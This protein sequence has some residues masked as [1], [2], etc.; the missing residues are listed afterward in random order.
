MIHVF[1]VI[2]MCPH[3]FFTLKSPQDLNLIPP[4]CIN[5]KYQNKNLFLKV[6]QVSTKTL[7]KVFAFGCKRFFI[8]EFVLLNKQTC[9]NVNM[10]WLLGTSR[11]HF[12]VDRT[13][14][15]S[16][17]CV[18]HPPYFFQAS[19]SLPCSL[20]LGFN[21]SLR[22]LMILC[23]CHLIQ[24]GFSVI[25]SARASNLPP[26]TRHATLSFFSPS[27]AIGSLISS[28]LQI[29]TLFPGV[30]SDTMWS[31]G[32]KASESGFSRC[33]VLSSLTANRDIALFNDS[34]PLIRNLRETLSGRV[35]GI[36]PTGRFCIQ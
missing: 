30:I 25:T 22:G 7:G 11:K 8:C 15:W 13:R 5:T 36:D 26:A 35:V 4:S 16:C 29:L 12:L 34:I 20:A 23:S 18:P 6:F 2:F 17:V 31:Q 27:Y 1:N 3:H 28:P 10:L 9:R 33:Y 19:L 14:N 21:F 24:R 32:K